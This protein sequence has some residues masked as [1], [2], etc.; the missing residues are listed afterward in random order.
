[1]AGVFGWSAEHT[2]RVVHAWRRR[3]AAER[4]GEAERND[5]SALRA[6]ETTLAGGVGPE[7][8]DVGLGS[9]VADR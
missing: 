4:A 7:S 1:M 2:D 6:Y 5:E 8:V 3:V 9:T